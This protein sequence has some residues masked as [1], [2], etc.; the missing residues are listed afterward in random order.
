[1]D[2]NKTRFA[3]F[4]RY[5]LSINKNFYRNIAIVTLAGAI[6]IALTGF[7]SRL[8]IYRQATEYPFYSDYNAEGTLSFQSYNW[9]LFTGASELGFLLFIMA[10]S[11]GCWA[12]NL[13]NKQGRITELT[14]PA[15]NLEKFLWHGLL[16][17]VG[18]ML[19]CLVSLLIADGINALLTLSYFGLDNGISSLTLN[20]FRTLNIQEVLK[21][22]MKIFP[23][24]TIEPSTKVSLLYFSIN[25]LIIT[26]IIFTG[27]LYFL[28]NGLK[29]KYNII[30]TYLTLQVLGIIIQI[31]PLIIS[32]F[33]PSSPIS[34]SNE[35]AE[36]LMIGLL[37]C[38]G[39][40]EVLA[41]IASVWWSYKLY[42]RAQIT[43]SFN[44]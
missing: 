17:S 1:M 41:T 31:T 35:D 11:L 36:N 29:Y 34:I 20:T 40:I 30:F 25:F 2:F 12:H 37:L 16:S 43:T 19:V 22:L 10:V 23:R 13:R 27:A 44:K 4:A 38:F 6:G 3:N 7:A 26:T 5:D 14:L 18:A 42:K 39:I 9:T 33:L 24:A 28:S 15:T 8:S 32:P 21:E